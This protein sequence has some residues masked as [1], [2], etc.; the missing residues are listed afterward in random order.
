MK[1]YTWW[2]IGLYA[3]V[4]LYSFHSKRFYAQET[5]RLIHYDAMG[6]YSY[7]LLWWTDENS[8]FTRLKA[9]PQNTFTVPVPTTTG[10]TVTLNKYSTGMAL[11]HTPF[12]W[13]GDLQARWQGLPR[14]GLSQPYR[15]WTALGAVLY[16]LLALVLLRAWLQHHCGE[17]A[18]AVALLGIGL[19]THWWHYTLYAPF[20][21]HNTSF[22]CLAALLYGA[23]R[24]YTSGTW[25]WALW[26]GLFTGLLAAT[27]LPNLAMGWIILL[28]GV[29]SWQTIR[30]RRHFLQDQWSTLVGAAGIVLLLQLPQLWYWKT[31]TGSWWVNPYTAN[32]EGFFWSQ[33]RFMEILIGYRKGWL[34]YTPLAMLCLWGMK[35][36]YQQQRG[37]FWAIGGYLFLQLYLVAAWGCWWYGGCFGLRPMVESMA[38][39]SLPLALWWE[40]QKSWR[41]LLSG[42]LLVFLMG[43]NQFQSHQY[44]YGLIHWEGMTRA[45]YW[46]AFGKIPPPTPD[47]H[48]QQQPLLLL[49]DNLAES[50]RQ[51]NAATIW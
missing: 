38:V 11:L 48:S 8:D 49:P 13:V 29:G 3:L 2:A 10:S 41:L 33:P 45:A 15:Y 51:K 28:G 46:H 9:L 6:Y 4:A 36:V 21:A 42:S 22:F 35:H 7:L 23:Q 20:M 50:Q 19:G 34:I 16:A 24:W 44:Q 40:H 25:R 27:R 1:R 26:L 47:F 30:E 5:T 14:D 12:F 18:T 39:L 17:G 32:G 43:L 37:W 31:A